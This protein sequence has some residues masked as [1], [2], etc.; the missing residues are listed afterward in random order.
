MS[1]QTA[2]AQNGRPYGPK[3]LKLR[4]APDVTGVNFATLLFGSFFGIAMMGF[5]NASQ[6]YLFT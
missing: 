5:V 6:P 1:E 3:F 4:I 2:A